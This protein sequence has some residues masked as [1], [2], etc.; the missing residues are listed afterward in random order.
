MR[1]RLAMLEELG[2]A[3]TWRTERPTVF[4][5]YALSLGNIVNQQG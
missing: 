2:D 1:G 3:A 4:E 5:K